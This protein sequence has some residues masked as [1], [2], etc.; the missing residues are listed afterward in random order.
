[1][2]SGTPFEHRE[3][4]ATSKTLVLAAE[5]QQSK[6]GLPHLNRRTKPASL[7]GSPSARIVETLI[8]LSANFL[9][10]T[11][12]RQSLL[13]PALLAWFQIVGV[14]LHFLNDIFRLNLALEPTQS[15][16]QRLALLQSNFCQIYH[17]P[18]QPLLGH[19]RAY[20]ICLFYALNWLSS[21]IF[22]WQPYHTFPWCQ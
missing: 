16:L 19:I 22:D 3:G 5:N 1:M 21:L 8:W 14:T 9:S 17:P 2:E 20:L 6:N 4:G 12:S 10:C 11:L 7:L 18:N 13:H 15:V